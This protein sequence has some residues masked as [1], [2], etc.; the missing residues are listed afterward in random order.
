MSAQHISILGTGLAAHCCQQ[1]LHAQGHALT[2]TPDSRAARPL[3]ILLSQSTQKLLADVF[4]STDLFAGLPRIRQRVVAWAS[5]EPVTLP[6]EAVVIS[7]GA[8]LD[9]LTSR[10]GGTPQAHS[11]GSGWTILTSQSATNTRPCTP[12]SFGARTARA[13]PVDLTPIVEPETC[14][15]ES[16]PAGWLFLLTTGP[17]AGSLLSVGGLAESLLAVSTL[18]A[19]KIR[20]VHPIAAEI[21]AYP[22][23]LEE[24][25]APGWLA[26]GSAAIAFDPLCGEGAGNA[27]REAILACAAIRAIFA[28]ESTQDVLTEYAMR[29]RLGFL[30]HLENCREF[31]TQ[32]SA[33]DFWRAEL[34]QLEEGLAWMRARLATAARPKF[35][36]RNFSLD[37]IPL[38]DR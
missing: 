19:P 13:H 18:I 2:S 29:L 12:R 4:N 22:R 33:T 20:Q 15:V 6:H 38:A 32:D 34:E 21:P 10:L 5:R 35:R 23:I 25:C 30:R 14:W 28:G 17:G 27:A 8:L 16:T 37:R 24:L 3:S 36:L 9:R 26:C 11:D 7:E 1:L 31:Y